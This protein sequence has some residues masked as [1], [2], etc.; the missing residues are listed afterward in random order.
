M[1]R[2]GLIPGSLRPRDCAS[3]D[4]L[5]VGQLESTIAFADWVSVRK[6]SRVLDLGA[7]L[8]GPARYL[9][10]EHAAEVVAVEVVEELHEAAIALTARLGLEDRVRHECAAISSSLARGPFDLVWL[11]HV[12]MH[13]P[14]K[15]S[16]YARARTLLGAEGRIVW[17][18]WLAGP[19]GEPIWPLFW[20]A[21]GAISFL[22]TEASFRADLAA[23]GLDLCRFEP[24][25][26]ATRGWLDKS[27]RALSL[28]LSKAESASSP[29]KAVKLERL[30]RLISE[31]ENAL[32][33]IDEARLVPF[34]AEARTAP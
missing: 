16:L 32:R 21:D 6:G 17:H 2:R 4:Q 18:D 15:R 28:S 26:E 23:E 20:S 22:S 10:E 27:H 1:A 25:A 9:A 11:E 13:I 7:G 12:D 14:D 34:F 31:T 5:H 3:V 24:I 29:Q 19:G 33:S 30:R 8:G